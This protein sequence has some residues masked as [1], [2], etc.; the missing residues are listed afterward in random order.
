MFDIT[1]CIARECPYAKTCYRHSKGNPDEIYQSYADLSYHCDEVN[2]FDYFI[3]L[4]KETDVYKLY[5]T[6]Q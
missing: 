3:P 1:M 5:K 6:L 2:G 4:G